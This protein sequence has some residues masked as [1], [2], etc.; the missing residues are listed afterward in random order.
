MSEIKK[1]PSIYLEFNENEHT[2]GVLLNA[3]TDTEQEMLERILLRILN[4]GNLGWIKRI[5]RR[6]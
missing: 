2:V 6:G 1:N 3:A 5:F 4:P